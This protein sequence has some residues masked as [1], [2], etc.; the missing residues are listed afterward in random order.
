[1]NVVL[2]VLSCV[3]ERGRV[4]DEE[5]GWGALPRPCGK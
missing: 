2:R 4:G 3:E 5:V 1:M